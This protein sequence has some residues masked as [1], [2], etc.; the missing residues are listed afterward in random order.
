MRFAGVCL[1]CVI[2]ASCREIEPV[3]IPVSITGYQ[4]QGSVT[5]ANGIVITGAQVSIFYYLDL[6]SDVP[7]DTPDVIVP[8]VQSPI[9]ISVFTPELQFIRHIAL[10]THPPPGI[11]PHIFWDGKDQYGIPVPCGKYLIRYMVDSVII[12]YSP[13]LIQGHTTTVTDS[14]GRF[15]ITGVRLPVGDLFDFY[16]S[17]GSFDGVYQVQPTVDLSVQTQNS[18]TYVGPIDLLENGV[19]TAAIIL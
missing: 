3:Q 9:D 18:A 7:T 11:L 6:V 4:I 8:S 16:L 17:D 10:T 13:V 1:L 12:K 14:L 5:T 19:T 2:A 15:T